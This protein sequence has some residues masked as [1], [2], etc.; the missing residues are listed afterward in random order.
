MALWLENKNAL[1]CYEAWPSPDV[2]ISDGAYGVGGFKGDT[3]SPADL[4]EWYKP[5]ILEWSKKAKPSTSLWFW[6]TEIGWA[7]VHPVLNA[8]GWEYVETI[9]WD[10][11]MSHIA[12]NVNSKTI[13]Q[14]PVATEISVLYRKKL[15]LPSRDGQLLSVKQWLR[16]EWKRSG[17]PLY[18]ANEACG[19]KNAATR[20]YLTQDHLWY[21]PPGDA[22]ENMANYALKHGKET[23]IPY[24]SLNG[25]TSPVAAE[26]D[27]L[28]AKWNYAHGHTNVWSRAQLAGVERI[29]K[30]EPEKAY[31]NVHLNQKPLEFMDLQIETTTDSGDMVW[32]PFGGLGS[33]CVSALRLGRS[34]CYAEVNPD[35]CSIARQRCERAQESTEDALRIGA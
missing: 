12:G 5:H 8:N 22:V 28:R 14:F 6:N 25:E 35:Y 24:F 11:G 2:I 15:T 4:G 3:F 30:H 1:E 23:D 32:E 33:A 16:S 18:A 7:N 17:L 19:T 27:A 10:K 21:W 34:A 29:K 9:V 31:E 20:K 26:W 13:R